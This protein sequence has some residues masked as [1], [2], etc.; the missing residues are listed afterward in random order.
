MTES[1]VLV[2]EFAQVAPEAAASRCY[3]L[4]PAKSNENDTPL[5]LSLEQKIGISFNVDY[6]YRAA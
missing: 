2:F 5:R 3:R 4:C 6:L 1:E